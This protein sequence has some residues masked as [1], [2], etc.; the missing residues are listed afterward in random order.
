MTTI[1]IATIELPAPG[2]KMAKITD[3]HGGSWQAYP[4]KL[5]GI[6]IGRRYEIEFSTSQF[7][8]KD[9][10]TINKAYPAEPVAGS[11][12][13]HT[14]EPRHNS[15]PNEMHFVTTLLAAFITSGQIKP[16]DKATLWQT[17]KDLRGCYAATF[18]EVS[19]RT[20]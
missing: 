10:R 5:V 12:N 3:R 17:V 15:A 11:G 13:G 1:E 16:G 14:S 2:K 19:N 20:H 6:E 18:G 8:G 4:D 7:K 9:Y